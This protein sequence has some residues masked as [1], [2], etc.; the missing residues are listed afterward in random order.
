MKR[1]PSVKKSAD[2]QRAYQRGKSRANAC[3]AVYVFLNGMEGNRL[4]ISCS[5]KIGNSVVRHGLARKLREIFRRNKNL[6]QGLDI[7]VVVRK[8]S[9]SAD[10]RKIERAYLE[11]CSRHHILEEEETDG[12]MA[13]F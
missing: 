8:A 2:Y 6:K 5:K 12:A 3:L 10:Y 4:G 7:I 9:A 11:L 1:F 13:E